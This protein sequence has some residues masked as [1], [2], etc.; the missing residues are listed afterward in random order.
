MIALSKEADLNKEVNSTEPSTLVRVPWL[1]CLSRK[2][3][4]QSGLI[5]AGK[6]RRLP[7][8]R[9]PE[10]ELCWAGSSFTSKYLTWQERLLRDE[11]S[12]LLGPVKYSSG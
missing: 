2:C 6:A 5:L 12:S 8:R 11:R 10:R 3:S 9:A 4:F 1:E 7:K